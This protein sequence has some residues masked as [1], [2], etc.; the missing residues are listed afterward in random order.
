MNDLELMRVRLLALYATDER[1]HMLAT[2]DWQKRPAPIAHLGRTAPGNTWLLNAA[3][4]PEQRTFLE[5]QFTLEPASMS[6]APDC[7][8]ICDEFIEPQQLW[9]GPAFVFEQPPASPA[10]PV[11]AVT[12]ENAA[13]LAGCFDDWF[14]DVPHQQPMF[15]A[16][17]D[18]EPVAICATVRRRD[19]VV[20]AGV[21]TRPAWRGRGFGADAVAGWA[22]AVLGAGDVPCY[23]TSADNAASINLANRLGARLYGHDFSLT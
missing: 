17:D 10:N 22:R 13:L 5:E 15:A 12:Q 18:G 20:E 1:G 3:I 9:M 23:S 19:G 4:R 6:A 11:V 8:A 7:L 2:G 16:C 21:E 14:E